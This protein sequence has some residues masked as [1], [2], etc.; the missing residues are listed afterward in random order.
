MML[1]FFCYLVVEQAY[2]SN[3]SH[4][5]MFH[6]ELAHQNTIALAVFFAVI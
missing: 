4:T 6:L 1:K 3:P 5:K 2:V